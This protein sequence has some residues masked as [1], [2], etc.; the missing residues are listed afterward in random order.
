[1]QLSKRSQQ[2]FISKSN[3]GYPS[4]TAKLQWMCDS[5]AVLKFT[6]CTKK[7]KAALQRMCDSEA[8]LKFTFC[9]KK[10]AAKFFTS[11]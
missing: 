8:V 2:V 11:I 5:E 6:F 4:Q 9:T 1:V 7:K 3:M 10:K